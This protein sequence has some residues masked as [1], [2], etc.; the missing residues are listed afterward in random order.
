LYFVH[1]VAF[2]TMTTYSLIRGYKRFGGKYCHHLQGMVL[3]QYGL[4]S[5][6]TELHSI[7][8]RR[9]QYESYCV[10]WIRFHWC[11]MLSFC[12]PLPHLPLCIYIRYSSKKLH[13][14]SLHYSMIN[15]T[16]L[17][18]KICKNRK[19]AWSYI[20]TGRMTGVYVFWQRWDRTTGRPCSWTASRGQIWGPTCVSRAT[21]S[22]PPSASAS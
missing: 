15:C 13:F 18:N 14:H 19:Q 20:N 8:L 2:D 9:P 17:S 10:I 5:P 16:D 12:C 22:R 21:A 4:Y 1:I 3:W 6:H 7:I 11:R